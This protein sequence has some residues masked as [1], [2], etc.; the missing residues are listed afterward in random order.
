MTLGRMKTKPPTLLDLAVKR[1]LKDRGLS[2]RD[3]ARKLTELDGR[4]VTYAQLWRRISQPVTTTETLFLTA[5][6]IGISESGLLRVMDEELGLARR[7][8]REIE[9]RWI[10]GAMP[11]EQYAREK[12]RRSYSPI[13]SFG[14]KG[15]TVHRLLPLLPEHHTFVEPFCGAAS[16]FFAKEPSPVEVLNDIDGDIANFFRVLRDPETFEGFRRKVEATPYSREQYAECQ[17]H[18]AG[19][20]GSDVTR[21]WAYFV[22]AR[23]S[24]SARVESGTW[25]HVI[26]ESARGIAAMN[27][28]WLSAIGR[29]P[30]VHARLMS[31]QIEN[32]D[33]RKVL[34]GYDTP[35]TLYFLDP[36]YT[37]PTRRRGGYKHEMT[38]EDHRDLVQVLL[39]VKGKVIL[40]GFP[41]DAYEPLEKAGWT[42]RDWNHLSYAP[43]RTRKT[44]LKGSG[45]LTRDVREERVWISPNCYVDLA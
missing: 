10:Q 8:E 18:L 11:F 24:F 34:R 28:K 12:L 9:G 25:G 15:R 13:P 17:A 33:F 14:G 1:L 27:S 45:A 42:T 21:A 3:V 26:T 29:L 22:L 30:E 36:P 40:T 16:L 43:G 19:D 7:E 2:L 39:S 23:Q 44:G 35:N 37:G 38:A 6:G 20:Q 32:L 41:S 5:R 31:A 4:E